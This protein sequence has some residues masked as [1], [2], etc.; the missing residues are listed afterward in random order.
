MKKLLFFILLLPLLIQ[1]QAAGQ[2]VLDGIYV[3]DS[4]PVI[5]YSA[6]QIT[7][8]GNIHGIVVYV[9][10]KKYWFSLVTMAEKEDRSG[11]YV[12]KKKDQFCW[13][14]SR[15]QL[16]DDFPSVGFLRPCTIRQ[17]AENPDLVE[18][19]YCD[20]EILQFEFV[21]VYSCSKDEIVRGYLR[22]YLADSE[23]GK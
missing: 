14:N 3:P 5:C 22:K 6:D 1:R 15:Y 17:Y 19:I 4:I 18:L 8:K 10:G 16:Y 2:D 20:G 13:I 23:Y 9:S 7:G 12:Y 11:F 21:D